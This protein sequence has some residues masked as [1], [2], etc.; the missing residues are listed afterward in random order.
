MR[1]RPR[2][3]TEASYQFSSVIKTQEYPCDNNAYGET[4]S[5][6]LTEEEAGRG[7]RE[8]GGGG[9]GGRGRGRGRR[10]REGGG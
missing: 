2:C 3:F 10:G 6:G 1:S 8:G 4:F 5:K 9:E 7:G